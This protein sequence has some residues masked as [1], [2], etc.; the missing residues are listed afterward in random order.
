MLGSHTSYYKFDPFSDV[1]FSLVD[2][3]TSVYF[4]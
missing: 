4:Y 3:E 2:T 1:K